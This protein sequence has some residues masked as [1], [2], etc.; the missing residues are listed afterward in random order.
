MQDLLDDGGAVSLVRSECAL[1]HVFSPP[2]SVRGKVAD[3]LGK[4]ETFSTQHFIC[5]DT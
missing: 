2:A 4:R 1:T 5:L 3:G